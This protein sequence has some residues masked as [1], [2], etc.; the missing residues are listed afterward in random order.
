MTHS[1]D[2][3]D[4]GLSF[5][6]LAGFADEAAGER[7]AATKKQPRGVAKGACVC[8]AV[9]LEFDIPAVWAWHDH[10]AQSRKAHG[11]V[12]A[13]YVGVWRSKVR[14]TK[15]ER[16]LSHY[17]DAMGVRSF[18][19]KCGAP[20][21]YVRKRSPKM[22]NLPRALFSGR[23][24]REPRYHLAIEEQQDWAYLGEKLVPLKGYPGVMWTGG[25]RKTPKQRPG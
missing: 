4:A 3:E 9:A 19:S 2:E 22:V 5:D 17:E 15:G 8:G 11:A 21:M 23:T 16:T 18:C 7:K 6:S 13:T 20:V 24:G 14:V 25:K 12:Y 10:S 1:S